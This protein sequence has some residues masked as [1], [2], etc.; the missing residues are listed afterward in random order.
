MLSEGLASDA[1]EIIAIERP[2]SMGHILLVKKYQEANTFTIS[3]SDRTI[4]TD[5][6]SCFYRSL[7]PPWVCAAGRG[8]LSLPPAPINVHPEGRS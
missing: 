3:S 1:L 7:S 6:N 4:T 2:K 5:V 8:V